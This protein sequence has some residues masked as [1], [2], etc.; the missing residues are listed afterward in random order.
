VIADILAYADEAG[1][2][3]LTRKTLAKALLHASE[4]LEV[5]LGVSCAESPA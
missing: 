5:D 1:G 2:A 3:D 4:L